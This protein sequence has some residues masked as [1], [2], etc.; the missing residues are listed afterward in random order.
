[1]GWRAAD[2]SVD[3]AAKAPADC[4]ERRLLLLA[5]LAPD[6]QQAILEGR[7][8][9]SLTLERLSRKQIPTAWDEQ[10]REFG[11]LNTAP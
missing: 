8:P 3:L 5:F 4:Y 11:F 2:G 1:M 7:Q 10:R 9:P 6:I